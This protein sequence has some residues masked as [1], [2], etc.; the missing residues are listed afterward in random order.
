MWSP[1]T[2]LQ[3]HQKIVSFT[4]KLAQYALSYPTQEIGFIS[5]QKRNE[6]KY[7]EKSLHYRV[8]K[9]HVQWRL[10]IT[11]VQ[12]TRKSLPLFDVV[13]PIGLEIL[14]LALQLR[15]VPS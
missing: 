14:I 11:L 7:E 12:N 13:T 2:L 3:R 1:Q 15:H 6:R 8:V 10:R 5:Y 9:Q 4:K